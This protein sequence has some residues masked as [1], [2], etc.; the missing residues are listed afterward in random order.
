MDSI[1]IRVHRGGWSSGTFPEND[2]NK[3]NNPTTDQPCSNALMHIMST[4]NFERKVYCKKSDH[5]QDFF[6]FLQQLMP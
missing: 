6:L 1:I 2:K 3:F 5:Y 4:L